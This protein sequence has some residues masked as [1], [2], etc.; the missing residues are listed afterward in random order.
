MASIY[1]MHECLICLEVLTGVALE[2]KDCKHYFNKACINQWL[3]TNKNITCPCCRAQV[4][5]RKKQEV[6][7][8]RKPPEQEWERYREQAMLD[9]LNIVNSLQDG[10]KTLKAEFVSILELLYHD[11]KDANTGR[12]EEQVKV[13]LNQRADIDSATPESNKVGRPS[14]YR[15]TQG[16]RPLTFGQ[17]KS[18][19]L[20]GMGIQ[21]WIC[22]MQDYI[23]FFM[24]Q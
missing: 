3:H 8:F 14:T 12:I 23:H 15:S 16:S 13:L 22:R 11:V 2:L 21:I 10:N 5:P 24:G 20:G 19:I 18:L 1:G 7:V 17:L 9:V 4:Q 6:L